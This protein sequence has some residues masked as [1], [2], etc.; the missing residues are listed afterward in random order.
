MA[1]S[2]ETQLLTQTNNIYESELSNGK[3]VKDSLELKKE[4]QLI[5]ATTNSSDNNSK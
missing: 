5:T 2:E 1:S 4:A 3:T